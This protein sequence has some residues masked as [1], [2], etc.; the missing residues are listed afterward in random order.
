MKV[1]INGK[2]HESIRL[3]LDTLA[4]CEIK[5]P[6]C[7]F[8]YPY[9]TPGGYGNNWWQL[10]SSFALEGYMW[11]D[12]GFAC[13]SV[14]NFI[15]VQKENGRIPLYGEDLLIENHPY[16]SKQ[17]HNVSSL[18]QLFFTAYELAS[19]SRDEA[20]I[21]R[22]YDLSAKYLGWW[23]SDRLDRETGLIT[24][25][26]EETFPPYLGV[27]REFAG[28]DTN[29]IV[30]MGARFAARLAK[31]LGKNEEA[32]EWNKFSDSV[33]AAVEK[34][35]W[36]EE[37]GLFRPI[38]LADKKFGQYATGGFYMFFDPK[39]P[40]GRKK[41]MIS[42]LKSPLF[43]WDEYPLTSVSVKDEMFGYTDSDYKW[44][45]SW[46]GMT[47]TLINR[48][49]SEGLEQAGFDAEALYLANRTVDLVKTECCEFYNPVTGKGYGAADYAW[50]ASHAI[51]MFL[52]RICGIKFDGWER[53][54]TLN[55]HTNDTVEIKDLC[56]G[57]YGFADI[58]IEGGKVKDLAL[59][60][61]GDIKPCLNK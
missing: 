38:Y 1:Y 33:F 10:D 45:F 25:L 13:K 52:E 17:K 4:K 57:D 14:E 12:Y 28:A 24:S 59:R 5:E 49:V 53:T 46:S 61:E 50:T 23:Q 20:F 26:F 2:E 6:I 39:L 9:F 51:S 8:T 16:H 35:L 60:A 42:N 15:G 31:R 3:A 54:L 32:K 30:A 43:K 58:K 37:S 44:N 48:Y 55:P 36:D 47:W 7:G 19:K 18:P 40:Q 41:R 22:M 11:H 56:L 34:H 27:E 29:V 21:G